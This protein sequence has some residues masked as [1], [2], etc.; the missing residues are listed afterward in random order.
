MAKSL[1]LGNGEMLVG[2]DQ[3]AQVQDLHFPYVGLE[4]HVS[5]YFIHRVG[6]WVDGGMHWF[7]HSD[8]EIVVR[9]HDE[10]F[11]GDT[12]AVNNR[13]GIELRIT[14]VVYNEKNILVREIVIHN[15]RDDKRDLKIF[16]GHEF[17]ISE[18]WRGDT[19][20]FDPR[21][22]AIIHYKGY[23]AFL[24]NAVCGKHHFDDYSV[25][26]F[27][28]EGRD[29]TFRDAENG[30]LSKNPI[31]HGSVDSVI[32]LSTTIEAK[33]RSVVHY[34]LAVGKSIEEVQDLNAYVF[35]KGPRH[36]IRTTSDYWHAWVNKKNFIFHGL[37]EDVIKLFQKSL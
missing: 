12:V 26:L 5:R 36:L 19:A 13:I 15:L 25:G 2:F 21:C 10:T 17:Q 6:V 24:A 32:G 34:W 18:S 31:E 23:R 29:G 20:Y 14:D 8:W 35:S 27:K 22:Q 33:G 37:D 3:R 9:C 16:F 4:N 11:A 30:S 1:T 7:E 28:I